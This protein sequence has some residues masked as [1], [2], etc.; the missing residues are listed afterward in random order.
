MN[1][2]TP[3]DLIKTPHLSMMLN[4]QIMIELFDS[5]IVIN[6]FDSDS[7]QLSPQITSFNF[8]FF[9]NEKISK[10]SSLADNSSSFIRKFLNPV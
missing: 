4:S 6:G 5:F 1:P 3:L 9:L 7:N 2:V 8:S 10:I